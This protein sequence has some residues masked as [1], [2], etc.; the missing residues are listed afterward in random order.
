[1]TS[2]AEHPVYGPSAGLKEITNM[3]M[4]CKD[5]RGATDLLE[6]VSYHHLK[7]G[8][9]V[10][11]K[12]ANADKEWAIPSNYDF[13]DLIALYN[14]DSRLKSLCNEVAETFELRLRNYIAQEIG[15]GAAGGLGFLALESHLNLDPKSNPGIFR[16]WTNKVSTS[17]KKS[18]QGKLISSV[19]AL[20]YEGEIPLKPEEVPLWSLTEVIEF[21]KL[22]TL[23]TLMTDSDRQKVASRFDIG[24]PSLL[25][26]IIKIIRETRNFGSHYAPLWCQFFNL[27]KQ[28]SVNVFNMFNGGNY[29]ALMATLLRNEGEGIYEMLSVLSYISKNT[30]GSD[31]WKIRMKDHLTSFESLNVPFGLERLG[32]VY[33]GWRTSAL[34][35]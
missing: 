32:F 1:M 5:A 17:M 28:V 15:N 16:D 33:T 11:F 10:A 6:R 22:E 35:S 21:G 3:G 9:L 14:F 23:Y 29:G 7:F 13:S 2:K 34:W 31:D 18:I 27:N 24:D 25:D 20:V 12:T 26:S 4:T 30:S 8:Y 19:N